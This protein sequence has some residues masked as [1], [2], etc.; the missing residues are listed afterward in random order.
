VFFAAA[1]FRYHPNT[2]YLLHPMK[3]LAT[4]E[5]C[6]IVGVNEKVTPTIGIFRFWDTWDY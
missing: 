1:V 5:V 6:K 4:L 2:E 3:S